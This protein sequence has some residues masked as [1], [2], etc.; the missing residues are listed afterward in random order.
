[1]LDLKP[2]T[3]RAVL[4]RADELGVSVD[5]AIMRAVTPVPPTESLNNTVAPEEVARRLAS[6]QAIVA[7]F[8]QRPIIDNRPVAEIEADLHRD[9][10]W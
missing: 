7:R 5:E 8:Q 9:L 10:G 6:I 3:E 1:M 2:E 4:A